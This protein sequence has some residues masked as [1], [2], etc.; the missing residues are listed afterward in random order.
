MAKTIAQRITALE[1]IRDNY[2]DGLEKLTKEIAEGRQKPS[3]SLDGES[4]N[5]EQYQTMLFDKIEKVNEL[6]RSQQA[7]I[8]VSRGR[9]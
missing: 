6:I 7:F 8:V 5:W 4:Y 9:A 1:N 3:Y 2:L